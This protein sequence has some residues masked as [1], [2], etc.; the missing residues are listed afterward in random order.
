MHYRSIIELHT[1][2]PNRDPSRPVPC[3]HW[4]YLLFVTVK[5]YTVK[6]NYMTNGL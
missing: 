1:G 4:L 2:S 3:V 6:C 5:L